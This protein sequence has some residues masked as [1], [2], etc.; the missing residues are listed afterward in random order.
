MTTTIII[1]FCVLLLISY[2][3]DLSSSKT[4]I[5]SVILL[6]ALGWFVRQSTNFL[7]ITLPDFSPFLPILGSIGLILI[8]LEG[9]LELDL[10]KSKIGLIKK[11]FLGALIPVIGLAFLFAYLFHRFGYYPFKDSLMNAIPLCIISS[12]IAIPSVKNLKSSQKEFVIYES[13]W[14]DIVGV[15]FFNF[16]FFNRYINIEAFGNFGLQLLIELVV[17][18]FATI[19]L[20]FLLSKIE[21]KIKF[22]PIILLV[23]LIYEI[24]KIYHLPALIFILMFGLSIGNIDRFKH[25]KW[26]Q[27]FSPEIL[28]KE[29]KKLKELTIEATFL[30]RSLFFLLFGYLI[31]IREVINTDS[32]KWAIIIVAIIFVVR[33]IQLLISRL[34]LIPLLFVS[35]RG[36]I[37]I[38]L[39]L[40]IAPTNQILLVNRSLIIQVILISAL[41][42]MFGLMITKKHKKKENEIEESIES[43]KD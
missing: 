30:I 41:I 7:G 13:S 40:S 36:L 43:K 1:T 18:V 4:K 37:T 35:P 33:L 12:A 26:I 32:L 39:F 15:I 14:S 16:I 3:F 17:S 21:T 23:I 8:V 9:S 24:S 20:S 11:S 42:M 29:V 6:L 25:F 31:E 28:T 22:V 2:F 38:L 19:L 27:R 5:P 34:P 10:N